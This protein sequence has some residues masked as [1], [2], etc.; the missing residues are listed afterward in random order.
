MKNI[1]RSKAYIMVATFWLIVCLL[2]STQTKAQINI[3]DS[4]SYSIVIDST[5]WNTLMV[6][7][8]ADGVINIVDSIDW[9]FTACNATACYVPQ[10]NNPYSFPLIY[11]QDTVKLCYD[12]FVYQDST[13]T[14]C[15]RCDSLVYDFMTDTWVIMDRGNPT[16]VIEEEGVRWYSYKVYDLLGKEL[17]YIPVGKMYI[18]DNKLYINK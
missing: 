10:G 16:F 8:N 18:R 1:S 7:G 9:N 14:I 15:N 11:P 6:T 13:T 3:C 17:H 5:T 4:L 2:C 12:A